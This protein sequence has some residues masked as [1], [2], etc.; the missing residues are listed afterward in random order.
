[1]RLKTQ[2]GTPKMSK[3]KQGA[4]EKLG[5]TEMRVETHSHHQDGHARGSPHS[6]DAVD[7]SQASDPHDYDMRDYST[8]Y[9]T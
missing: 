5:L 8:D 1:M 4:L 2:S 6:G 7:D 9:I 3:T